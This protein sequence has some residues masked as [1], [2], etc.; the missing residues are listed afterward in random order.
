M[1]HYVIVLERSETGYAAFSP[2]VLGCVATGKTVEETLGEM[3]S[4]LA[5]HLEGLAETGEP[6]PE[7]KGLDYHLRQTEPVVEAGD[8]VTSIPR[9][10]VLAGAMI[11]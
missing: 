1:D 9:G 4:A 10:E 2:D 7:G 8:F 6:I 11:P 3:R 5:F